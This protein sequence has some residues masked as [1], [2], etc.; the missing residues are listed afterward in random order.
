[1][2]D[3]FASARDDLNE[4]AQFGR[5]RIVETLLFDQM[6]GETDPLHEIS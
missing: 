5:N 6:L 1:M 2:A 4:Q 3:R